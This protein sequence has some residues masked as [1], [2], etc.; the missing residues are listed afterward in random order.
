MLSVSVR[1]QCEGVSLKEVLM[2]RLCS[3]R[4]L[5]AAIAEQRDLPHASGRFIVMP[6]RSR[7]PILMRHTIRYGCK[8]KLPSCR[9]F[10]GEASARKASSDMITRQDCDT[11]YDNETPCIAHGVVSYHRNPI[12]A[13]TASHLRKQIRLRAS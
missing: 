11:S 4:R 1:S 12:A 2:L 13:R 8:S 7:H 6:C 9:G 3:L 10:C 5:Q